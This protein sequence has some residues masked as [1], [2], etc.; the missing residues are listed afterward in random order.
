MRRSATLLLTLLLLAAGC[1]DDEGATTVTS[2]ISTTAVT[3]TTVAPT[4]TAATTTTAPTTTAPTT[5]ATTTMATTLY[6]ID[7]TDFFPDVFGAPGDPHGSGCVVG[8]DVLPAGVWFGFAE[9]VSGGVITFDLACFFTGDAAVAAATAD[10]EEAFDFYVRNQN[11]KVYS[12]PI[13]PT[14]QVYYVDMITGPEPTPIAVSS[15]PTADSFTTCP[16]EY[17]PVWLY[18]NGGVATGIVEQYLP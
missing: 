18:V 17:C 12:V 6:Q 2:P 14:A 5:M 11:P 15:W 8:A 1:G 7:P 10:G 13:S 3:T 16:G 4:T 9:A